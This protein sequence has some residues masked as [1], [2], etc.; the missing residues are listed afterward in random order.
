MKAKFLKSGEG[1]ALR[2]LGTGATV[3]VDANETDGAFEF[4][5]MDAVRG[6]DLV[7]HRHPWAETYYILEGEIELRVGAR[8]NRMT[9]GD[10]ATIPARA[11]HTFTVLSDTARFLHVSIGPGATAVFEAAN[12]EFPELPAPAEVPR[13]LERASQLGLEFVLPTPA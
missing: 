3:K 11:V 2:V 6:G 1:E 4:V 7:P 8:T 9:A 12:V 13:L 5:V 10:F